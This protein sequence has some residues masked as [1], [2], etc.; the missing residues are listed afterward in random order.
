M[1]QR[2]DKLGIHIRLNFCSSICIQ[3]LF[4]VQYLYRI[5][6][7]VHPFS[8]QSGI[9]PDFSS[10]HPF[11]SLDFVC[12]LVVYTRFSFC[13]Y[14]FIFRYCNLTFVPML[15]LFIHLYSDCIQYRIYTTLRFL[16]ITSS[17]QSGIDT[18]FNFCW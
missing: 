2:F 1:V 9:V 12:N 11:L 10:V 16:Y 13:P 8:L 5:V 18:R 4:T 15:F 7:S 3:T 17:L 14:I 6:V